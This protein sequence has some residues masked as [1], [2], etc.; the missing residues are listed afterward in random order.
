MTLYSKR[1]YPHHFKYLFSAHH[2]IFLTL[3]THQRKSVL[4]NETIH[5][6]LVSLW[7]DSNEWRVGRYCIM[8]DHIHL[9]VKKRGATSESLQSWVYRWKANFSRIQKDLP[10]PIWQKDFWD[11]KIGSQDAYAAKWNYVRNN[12]VRHG[13][14]MHTDQWFYQGEIY[15]LSQC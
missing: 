5:Q 12:P 3:C 8:P 15:P 4:A 2:I 1:S 7:R 13:Y 14:V 10:K 9:F 6:S 11:T